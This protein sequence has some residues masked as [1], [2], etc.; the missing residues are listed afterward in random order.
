MESTSRTIVSQQ[1]TGEAYDRVIEDLHVLMR[2]AQELLEATVGD[3]SERV[4]ELRS[5]LSTALERARVTCQDL[6]ERSLATAR[7]AMKRADVAIRD[8][9]YESAGAAFGIGLV[10]GVLVTRR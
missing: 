3:A 4:K 5:R 1:T 7:T 10:L 2:D 9:P 8:H 6:E